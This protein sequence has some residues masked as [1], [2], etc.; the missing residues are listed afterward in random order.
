MQMVTVA[1]ILTLL[2]IEVA[3][4]SLSV[5]LISLAREIM[6]DS[7]ITSYLSWK[8]L[9]AAVL[10]QL[11]C[12][13]VIGDLIH[14]FCKLISCFSR[15]SHLFINETT[16]KLYLREMLKMR[17]FRMGSKNFV[18]KPKYFCGIFSNP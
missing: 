10:T 14:S 8:Q 1:M 3:V 5:A 12:Y 6:Q 17:I 15:A 2:L 11:Q 9:L 13:N 7:P 4:A 16:Y 18:Q